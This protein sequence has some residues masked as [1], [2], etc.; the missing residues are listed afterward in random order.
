MS[1]VFVSSH[2]LTF[3]SGSCFQQSM[4]QVMPASAFSPDEQSKVSHF[5]LFILGSVHSIQLLGDKA[6]GCILMQ[7]QARYRR[8][9]VVMWHW[10]ICAVQTPT[11]MQQRDSSMCMDAS[12]GWCWLVFCCSVLAN[13]RHSGIELVSG[14]CLLCQKCGPTAWA[15]KFS[16]YIV[17]QVPQRIHMHLQGELLTV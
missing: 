13:R 14:I 7:P 1:L 8:A 17:S 16:S 15:S 4:P 2:S 10:E 9:S 11:A 3:C 12:L 5:L 6:A